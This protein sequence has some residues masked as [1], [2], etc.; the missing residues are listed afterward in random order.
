MKEN[1]LSL[2]SQ[3]NQHLKGVVMAI[4]AASLWGLQG[5]IV[6][7]LF[8]ITNLTLDWVVT[9]RL[10]FSGVI[11]F[12]FL[13]FTQKK[14]RI[15]VVWK[16][17]TDIIQL[18]S[19]SILGLLGLQ[20]SFFAAIQ[21]SDAGTAAILQYLS[22][23]LIL[24]YI[25][26]KE[27]KRPRGKEMIALSLTFLGLLLLITNGDISQLAISRP[28]LIWGV[29]SAIA[30]SYYSLKPLKLIKKYNSTVVTMW[31]ML[32]GSAALS[33]KSNPF[34]VEIDLSTSEW[35]LVITIVITT[36]ISFYLYLASLSFITSSEASTL[37]IAE[38]A[39][40]VFISIFF[41]GVVIGSISLFGGLLIIVIVVLMGRG[42]FD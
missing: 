13:I 20:Y 25:F 42:F 35:L 22:P 15:F 1:S 29:I 21:H 5:N 24:V 33:L 14:E 34:K 3:K 38:P 30:L 40:A 23:S 32:I 16:D 37:T 4:V 36:F 26:F 8:R 19:F 31:S 9:V 39:T 7:H 2:K 6:D 17:K 28:A 18:I 41:M 27:K 12:L 11:L 10:F